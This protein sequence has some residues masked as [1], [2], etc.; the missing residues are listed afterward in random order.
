[1]KAFVLVTFDLKNAKSENY[2]KM[3]EQLDKYG[4]YKQLTGESG[5]EVKLPTTA[6]AG[7]F[8]TKPDTK[9]VKQW[10]ITSAENIRV[11]I[12]KYFIFCTDGSW[13]WLAG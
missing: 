11:N 9:K 1:M 8:D 10:L 4:L 2:E 6:F 5:K 12:G 7:E 13:S 3:A